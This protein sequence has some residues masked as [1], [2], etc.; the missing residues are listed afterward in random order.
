MPSLD[1]R[2]MLAVASMALGSLAAGRAAC[3]AGPIRLVVGFGP[4]SPMDYAA[5]LIAEP[6]SKAMA[7]PVA[8]S[9][10]VGEGSRRAALETIKSPPDSGT[11]LV[12]DVFL[13]A[14]H[15]Q[16]GANLL[17][18]LRPIAKLSRGVSYALVVRNDSP[19]QDW[20]G[21]VALASGSRPQ[22]A[23][24]GPLSATTVLL[25]MVEKRTG[26]AFEQVPNSSTR[27][28]LDLVLKRS[29]ALASIDT[30]LALLHNETSNDKVRVLATFGAQRSPEL[31]KV[32]TFAEIAGNP[33]AA[34][35][36][37]FA[38]FAAATVDDRF[39]ARAEE[40]FATISED[41]TI[42]YKAQ[43][44]KFPLQIEGRDVLLQTIARDRRVIAGLFG[45]G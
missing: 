39:A 24:A 27:E 25:D 3:A 31:P 14:R 2:R 35:T 28:A 10:V 22:V 45:P 41:E 29:V 34:F 44:V 38:V 23:T 9:H 33:K 43:Q 26:L 30:R 37:S 32:P 42:H 11:L 6:L 4:R 21:L 40:A 19:L 5:Q 8:V 36:Q 20:A 17:A 13:L 1:R 18:N 15:D 16:T 12:A 7:Q